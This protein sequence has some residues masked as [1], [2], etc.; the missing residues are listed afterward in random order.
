MYSNEAPLGTHTAQEQTQEGEHDP[1]VALDGSSPGEPEDPP[2][3]YDIVASDD[4]RTGRSR[5]R[6]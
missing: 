5:T 3:S 1:P 6:G 2:P 4:G